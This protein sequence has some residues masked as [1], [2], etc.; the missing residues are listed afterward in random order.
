MIPLISKYKSP[1]IVALLGSIAGFLYWNFIGCATGNCGIT[2]NWESS[3]G[4][5]AVMGWF[6][7][8]IAKGK[9]EKKKDL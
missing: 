8:D 4:F 1:I 3:I 7:G 9:A 2:A 6:I 5:G